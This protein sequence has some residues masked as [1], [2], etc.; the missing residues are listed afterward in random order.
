MEWASFML[1][2]MFYIVFYIMV[3]IPF[4]V[5][6]YITLRSLDNHVPNTH[7]YHM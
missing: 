6:L 3:Y 2:I 1:Y 4:N 7:C 5:V